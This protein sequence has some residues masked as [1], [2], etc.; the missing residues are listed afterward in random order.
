MSRLSE[1]AAGRVEGERVG[2]KQPA[3]M[4]AGYYGLGNL[5]DEALRL[6]LVE[7]LARA[8]FSR[9]FTLVPTSDRPGEVNRANPIAVFSA[10]RR[11]SAVVFG[12][13]GLLQNCTSRR[14]LAY[15]LSLILLARAAR[16][17][18]LLLGQG[19]GPIRGRLARHVT[20][21][22][23][24]HVRR[25]GCR[26]Q[27]SLAF[28]ESLGCTGVLDGDLLFLLRPLEE[29]GP[30]AR[31]ASP[32]IVLA[33]KG[34]GVAGTRRLVL[35]GREL[36]RGLHA[37][38]GAS[39][40]FLVSF[41]KQDLALAR[42]LEAHAEVPCR[43]VAPRTVDEASEALLSA[44]LLIGSRLHALEIGLRAGIPLLALGEEA[45]IAGFVREVRA[46]A[47]LEIPSSPALSLDAVL[48]AM[49]H[50][51]GRSVLLA[52]YRALHERTTRAFAAAVESLR[53]DAV[54][55]L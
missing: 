29:T 1:R 43:L 5:G 13:G 25:V 53:R 38:T 47:E 40:T 22:A 24:R 6:V 34:T 3:L 7:A 48:A 39:F 50:A 10:M 49:E 46:V 45:K 2:E 15:Y 30:H 32:R 17:P 36:L 41:P 37:E 55:D 23:L 35:E 14:S 11:S 42:A 28:V 54:G 51:A 26:D 44:D 33:L 19:I 20:R 4:I 18:V 9:L 21:G 27:G 8:G 16:R 12:G 31:R 52:A